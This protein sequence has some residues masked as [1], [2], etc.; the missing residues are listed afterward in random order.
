ML[1]LHHAAVD[2]VAGTEMFT[3]LH[4]SAPGGDD[5]AGGVAPEWAPEDPPSN[6][7]LLMRAG[8]NAVT[9]PLGFLRTVAPSVRHMPSTLRS[10]GGSM[11]AAVTATRFNRSIG[12]HRAF[13]AAMFDLESLKRIRDAVPEAKINDVAL[14]LVGGALR[15]YLDD[16]GELPSSS[17]IALVPV[18]LRPTT[19]QSPSGSVEASAGGNRFSM[20]AIPMATDVIDPRARLEAIQR[21]TAAAKS[22]DSVSASSLTELSEVLPGAL[23]GS[24][25]RA[26]VRTSNRAGRALAVHTIVTNVP[27]P[28][29]P[30][31]LCG[32][33]ALIMTGMA[34][35]VDG[36][37]LINGVGSYNGIVPVSF[38]S[39]REMMPDP[40]FYEQCL[41]ESFAELLELAPKRRAP[42][43]TKVAGRR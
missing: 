27:G 6:A 5:L 13:G 4:D 42:R 12:A 18:S 39:D 22:S 17:L 35:V 28:Q 21:A 34:P 40:E 32:A 2:G 33:E 41:D 11:S 25:H 26:I 37:G 38:T 31:Y 36:M 23:L 9:R 30:L 29:R 10:A 3:V 16:K 14:A 19:T 7:A 8:M 1:K 15:R 43:R 24:V 20:M